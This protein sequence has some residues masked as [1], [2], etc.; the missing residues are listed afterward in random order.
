MPSRYRRPWA[1]A[2]RRSPGQWQVLDVQV[3]PSDEGPGVSL[4]LRDAG[5]R[6]MGLFAVRAQ[7]G[8]AARPASATDGRQWA[9]YWQVRGVA[10]V[11]TGDRSRRE[12]M[13]DAQGLERESR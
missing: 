10:F 12:L 3:Y 9:A 5:G 13:A 8:V 1:C 2:C 7:A 11:L 4:L 6:R